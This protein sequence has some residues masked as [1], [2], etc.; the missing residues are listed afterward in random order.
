[1]K[2]TKKWSPDYNVKWNTWIF[3]VPL[4]YVWN[5]AFFAVFRD[6]I[7]GHPQVSFMSPVLKGQGRILKRLDKDLISN[8]PERSVVK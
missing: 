5:G 4:P 8:R 3:G 7:P 6:V 1:M 2:S